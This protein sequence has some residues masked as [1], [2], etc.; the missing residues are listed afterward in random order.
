MCNGLP[1]LYLPIA[2]LGRLLSVLRPWQATFLYNNNYVFK[3]YVF[4]ASSQPSQ[5][6]PARLPEGLF[7]Y[8]FHRVVRSALLG[9]GDFFQCCQIGRIAPFSI[10]AKIFF[11]QVLPKFG[12]MFVCMYL[13][14]YLCML[15]RLQPHRST[16]SFETMA[17]H[18]SW[19]C[20]KRVFSIF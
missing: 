1:C 13:C 18:S 11:F 4:R 6:P 15:V 5:M 16:Q 8:C 2:R 9:E 17:Q 14:M 10:T 20:L 3:Q 12:R 19:G 7:S